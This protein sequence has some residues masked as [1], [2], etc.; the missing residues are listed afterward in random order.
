MPKRIL[1]VDDEPHLVSLLETRLRAMGFET[2]S[3]MDGQKG[4]EMAKK[5]RPDLI[6]LDLMLPRMDGL[7]VCA[8]LKKDMRYAHIPVILFTA[9]V[10]EQDQAMGQEAGAE[11]YVTKPFEPQTLMIKIQELLN[12]FDDAKAKEISG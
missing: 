7:K 2:L 3:A 11:A 9:K 8:L 1:V 12:L 6:I 10:Q 5:E 4:L